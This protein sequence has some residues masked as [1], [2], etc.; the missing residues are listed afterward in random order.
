LFLSSILSV[1]TEDR[2]GPRNVGLFTVQPFDPSDNP[3]ELH[4]KHSPGK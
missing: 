4:C 1:L 3:K 2:D